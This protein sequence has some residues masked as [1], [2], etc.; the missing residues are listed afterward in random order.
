MHLNGVT[1]FVDR[2]GTLNEDPG[3][4]KHPADLILYPGVVEGVARLKQGG[5]QVV[6]VTNQS[7]IGRGLLTR[8]DLQAVHERLQAMLKQGGGELDGIF[9]CPHVPDAACECRKPKTGLIRQAVEELGVEVIRSYVVGD[10]RCDMELAHNAGSIGVLV[11]T[12]PVSQEA[13]DAA[14]RG[15]FSIEKNTRSFV[16]AVDWILHDAKTRPWNDPIP[17]LHE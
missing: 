10:K 2:D 17:R 1:I 16:E 7:G 15:L 9:F 12:T 8:T 4:L 11:S 3:Y 14:S 6:L 13:I 5:C